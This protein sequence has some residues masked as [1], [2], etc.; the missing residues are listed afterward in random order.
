M[1][2]IIKQRARNKRWRLKNVEAIKAY[3]KAYRER[4]RD[5]KP[6]PVEYVKPRHAEELKNR[7]ARDWGIG[8]GSIGDRVRYAEI[9][10][11]RQVYMYLLCVYSSLSLSR[12]GFMINPDKPFDH[13]TVLHSKNT[14]IDR[15][16]TEKS[17]RE[18]IKNIENDIVNR[19][20]FVPFSSVTFDEKT[21]CPEE[22]LIEL[23]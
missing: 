8:A 2:D 1:R 11:A 16:N 17:Y 4:H 5:Q 20:I 6:Q 14:V 13:S 22:A 19:K 9:K 15:I 21:E 3:Q 7:V 23:Q 12:I 18:R 10:D